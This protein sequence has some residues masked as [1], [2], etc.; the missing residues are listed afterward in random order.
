MLAS[1][2]QRV[3]VRIDRHVQLAQHGKRVALA[4]GL[5][6]RIGTRDIAVR[7]ID[8][9]DVPLRGVLQE[10][11]RARRRRRLLLGNP[12]APHGLVVRDGPLERRLRDHPR[13]EWRI[14]QNGLVQIEHDGRRL[15][16]EIARLLDGSGPVRNPP[17]RHRA[18][19]ALCGTPAASTRGISTDVCIQSV[20]L[21]FSC[22]RR[23]AAGGVDFSGVVAGRAA[24][25]QLPLTTAAAATTITVTS[26]IGLSMRCG[27]PEAS[28]HHEH[29]RV[30][31]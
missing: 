26:L 29:V 4:A 11:R 28:P 7:D 9:R 21:R 19:A 16:G 17:A 30:P 22:V 31:R 12:P 27:S 8:R 10:L 14:V 15:R 25:P 18:R 5:V 3:A 2:Q 20:A 1:H 6:L 24:V 13:L 23:A